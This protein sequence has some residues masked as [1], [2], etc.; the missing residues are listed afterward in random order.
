M[1][2]FLFIIREDLRKI[3]QWNEEQRYNA[4]REMDKWGEVPH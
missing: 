4:I 1:E 3:K 2:K